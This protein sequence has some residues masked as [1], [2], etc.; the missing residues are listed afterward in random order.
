MRNRI[1]KANRFSLNV[2]ALSSEY[3]IVLAQIAAR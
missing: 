3:G 2:G 1:S